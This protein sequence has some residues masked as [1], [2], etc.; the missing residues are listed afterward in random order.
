VVGASAQTG[1]PLT[2]SPP[3]MGIG[4]AL[5][6]PA[7][8][9]IIT[10]VF[11]REEQ[12]KAIGIWAAMAAVGIGLGPL[13]GGA[14]LE[15]FSWP[16]VF[17]INVPV[18]ALAFGLGIKYVPES[19]D[20]N[21]GRLDVPGAVL[22]VAALTSLVWA[23]IET[24]ERGW[25]DPA[26][27]GAAAAAIVFGAAF[28]W[29]QRSAENP[30]LD[31]SLFRRPSFSVGSFS[32]SAAFFAL[33]GMIF[34]LTQYLQVVQGASALE[35]GLKMLP[36]AVGLVLGNGLAT[37][38][39]QRVG[40]RLQ[41]TAALLGLSAVLSTAMFW[42]AG[43]SYWA[44]GLFFLLVP[45]AMGNIMSPATAAVMSAVP[46]AK[47]GV[48]SA[49]NDVNRMVA[50]ALGVAVVGSLGGSV[51]SSRVEDDVAGLPAGAEHA[52]GDSVGGAEAVASDLPA[53]AGDALQ[54]A[55]GAAYTD[56]LGLALLA[57]A[58]VTLIA[59]AVAWRLLPDQREAGA[60]EAAPEPQGAAVAAV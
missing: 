30:L 11:P 25:L 32:I 22:S 20:P 60:H 16:A 38:I 10:D 35:A 21:P 48:G 37:V 13:V 46:R 24:Q 2:L 23:I 44:I 29:R 6:M 52:A 5:I 57:A 26:V 50:G 34:L 36:V 7:T 45:F 56:A 53:P 43:T 27:L 4:A 1:S 41:V 28:V 47:A 15:G 54:A 8:L 33:F 49:M 55:A 14:L 51:Y 18:V 31:V 42:D 9:S 3:A 17:W 12:A 40:A 19:R 39:S 58:A 59:A